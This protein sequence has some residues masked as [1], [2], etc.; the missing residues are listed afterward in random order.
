MPMAWAG[1]PW[2]PAY[3]RLMLIG[4]FVGIESERGIAWRV[5]D[6]LSLRDFVGNGIDES[7]PDRVTISRTR[8]LIAAETDHKVFGWVLE[9]LAKARLVK[10]KTMG[11]DSTTL[12]ANAAMKL[13]V[14]PWRPGEDNRGVVPGTTS[15]TQSSGRG[16][17][18][19]ENYQELLRRVAEEEGETAPDAAA[20]MRMDRKRKKKTSK[21]EWESPADPEPEITK[22]KDRRTGLAFRVEQAVDLETEPLLQ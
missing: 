8:R 4:C 16:A 14:R 15:D 20:L 22:L 19:G 7:T 10:G 9:Q 21:K 17:R 13:I 12:E 11:V 2:F 6:S 18:D 5:S 3:F 1:H